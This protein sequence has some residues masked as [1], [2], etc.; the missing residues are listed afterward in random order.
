MQLFHEKPVLIL[1]AIA[2]FFLLISLC[3]FLLSITRISG[4][5]ILRFDAFNG[6]RLFGTSTDASWFLVLGLTVCVMNGLLAGTFYRRERVISY[7]LIGTNVVLSLLLLI[8][9][10]LIA[11]VN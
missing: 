9:V 10:A 6:V 11:S 5:L 1:S 3:I 2:G 7:L 8:L 4:P